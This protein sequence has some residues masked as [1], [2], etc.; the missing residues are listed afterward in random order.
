MSHIATAPSVLIRAA[1]D[2]D[3]AALRD[4]A[5]LDS[6]RVPTGD[7]LVA[8]AGGELIAA[9]ALNGGERIADPFRRTADVLELLELRA[10]GPGAVRRRRGLGER[11]GLRSARAA[12]LARAA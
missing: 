4:L 6:A 10:S 9:M 5:A 1:R 3:D 7:V 8:E 12:G 11:L 2:S